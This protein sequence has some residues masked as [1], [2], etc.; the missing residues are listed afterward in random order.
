[1]KAFCIPI[2]LI[3]TWLCCSSWG[4]YAHKLINQTAVF[5]LPTTLAMFYKTHIQEI[6]ERAVDADKRCYVDT[7]ESPR[8][9]IDIDDYKD[10]DTIPIHWSKAKEKFTERRLLAAG[11]VPWQI[12]FTY[13]KLVAAFRDRD[14]DRIIRHSADLGHYISDA[15]VPLHTTKNY[16]GQYSNQI[17]IHAFWESRLPEMFASSYSLITGKAIFIDDPLS[18][19]WNIVHESNALVDSVLSLEKELTALFSPSQKMSYIV[20]NNVLTR[21][22]SD[23]YAGAYH[24]ALN[25]MV[26]R[27]M[28]Q[29]IHAVGSLWYSAWIEAGQPKLNKIKRQKEVS[30]TTIGPPA[31]G[32]ILG[33]EEW[34]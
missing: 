15:H 31:S 29:A 30:E 12:S 22:Y 9:F 3:L 18:F 6:T 11:I 2:L 33:R 19:A 26:H 5:T 21:T 7:L 23:Q 34:H 27:R 13:Q 32:R 10:H 20:R 14:M 24:T 16:N 28:T 4:F 17:G 1:M 25:G 8:H